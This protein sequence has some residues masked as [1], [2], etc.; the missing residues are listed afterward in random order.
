MTATCAF[1]LKTRI[2]SITSAKFC[3]YPCR[4][5]QFLYWNGTCSA[6]CMSPLTQ[7]KQGTTSIQRKFCL[8][9]CTGSNILYWNGLCLPTCNPPLR[10]KI[11]ASLTYCLPPCASVFDYYYPDTGT[12][13]TGCPSPY[14]I[15][16][17]VTYPQ[18]LAPVSIK[19][20]GWFVR[21]IL[22]APE[23]AGTTTLTGLTRMMQYMRYLNIKMPP[24]LERLGLS[25]G[26]MV[27]SFPIDFYMSDQ[28]KNKFVDS[29]LPS[30]FE[31][32]GLHSSFLVN[33]WDHL[34][35]ICF[36]LLSAIIFA[37]LE[38][39]CMIYHWTT[40]SSYI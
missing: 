5:T 9:G 19:Q 38:K 10:T 17:G 20:D 35:T 39:I 29:K 16:Y 30:V 27:L 31:K 7:S 12:C 14:S 37:V 21:N 32:N 2:D 24:R 6:T 26:K 23:D 8:Y 18:C 15:D 25:R 22:T 11:E 13:K 33:Y 1:P 34:M 36:V 3:E 28:L 40:F 4:P